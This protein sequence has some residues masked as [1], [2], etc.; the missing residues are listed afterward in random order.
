[1]ACFDG[2]TKYVECD[3]SAVFRVEVRA[4][5]EAGAEGGLDVALRLEWELGLPGGV[6]A[7]VFG[8]LGRKGYV[9]GC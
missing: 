2:L 6:E 8:N 4:W 9:E 5:K 1:M 3:V 7:F